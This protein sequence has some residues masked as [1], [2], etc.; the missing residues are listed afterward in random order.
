MNK[1]SHI[2]LFVFLDYTKKNSSINLTDKIKIT[3]GENITALF[4]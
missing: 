3:R 2:A 4:I 1:D